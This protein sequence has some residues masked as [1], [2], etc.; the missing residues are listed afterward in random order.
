M[1]ASA[2]YDWGSTMLLFWILPG[3]LG[4]VTLVVL[5]G[6]LAEVMIRR[7]RLSRV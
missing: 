1:T 6:I 7:R 3:Y 2:T 4:S 5:A